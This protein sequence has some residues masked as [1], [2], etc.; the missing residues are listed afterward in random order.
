MMTAPDWFRLCL[1][2]LIWGATFPLI[3]VAGPHLPALTL[4]WLR[5]GIAALALAAV[6][7]ATGAAFPPRRR[8]LALAV[9]GGLNNALPFVLITLAQ[10]RI[11]GSEAAILNATTPLFTLIVAAL[12]GQDRLSGAR[13]AG[14]AAGLGGVAVLAGTAPGGE[15]AAMALCLGAALSYALAGVWGRGRLAGLDPMAAAFGMLGAAALMLTPAMLLHDRPWTLPP[16][17]PS[18]WGAVLAL[19]L[20]GSALAYRLYFR[21]LADVGA[22]NLL[23]VTF[24]VPVS[25]MA[26]SVA[27]LGE[28]LLPRHLAGLALILSGLALASRRPTG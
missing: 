17:P 13:V 28:V 11:G 3:E 6:L 1:L 20:L 21:L 25:A 19:A 10:G 14:L 26:I 27:A 12:A 22:V 18:A 15:A 7:W 9:M 16:P 5:V 2:A 24:L 23:L 8:W 4:V